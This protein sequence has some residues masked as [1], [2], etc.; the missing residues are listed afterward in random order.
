MVS[1]NPGDADEKA[2]QIAVIPDVIFEVNETY[3]LRLELSNAAGAQIGEKNQA[4]VVI[5]NDDGKIHSQN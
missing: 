1:F 4:Q 3:T 2:V 5:I